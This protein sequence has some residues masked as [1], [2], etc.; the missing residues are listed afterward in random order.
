MAE[1][2]HHRKVL[3]VGSVPLANAKEVFK[4]IGT[5]RRD[6]SSH[7]RRGNRRSYHGISA[8]KM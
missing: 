3:L 7:P 6:H 4:N 5:V 2:P 1:N 8:K